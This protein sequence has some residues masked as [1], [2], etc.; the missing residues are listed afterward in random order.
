[1]KKVLFIHACV[2][3]FLL[4]TPIH[5][6]QA[7]QTITRWIGD[8]SATTRTVSNGSPN[9]TITYNITESTPGLI[10]YALTQSGTYSNSLTLTIALN[11]SGN[12]SGSYYSKAVQAG[13]TT[14]TVCSPQLG[15]AS[16]SPTNYTVFTPAS[17]V[18]QI[19]YLK[20]GAFVNVPSPLLNVLKG[21]TVTFKAIPSP[22]GSL[23]FY[24]SDGPHDPTW[25]GVS[26]ATGVGETTAVTFN[27]LSKNTKDY[28]TVIATVQNGGGSKTANVIVADGVKSISFEPID[29][30]S[31][32]DD[33]P[34]A[35][36]GKRVFPD[37]NSPS[38]NTV[39]RRKVRV[40]ALTTFGV[41]QTIYFKSFDL[42]DPSTDAAPVDSN[43]SVV[44]DNRG[45]IG[46]SQQYGIL[47]SVGGNGTTN[48]VSAI[49]DANG[50]ASVDLTVT[51][52][53]G[54]NFMVAASHDS[55]Y[56]NGLSG[57]GI[58]LKDSGGNTVGAATVKAKSS[59]MLTVWRRMHV[60][61]DSMGNV[62]GNN[63]TGVIQD[64]VV[65]PTTNT[66]DLLVNQTLEESRFENG[67]IIAAGVR[68]AVVS[69]TVDIV[70]I[71]GTSAPPTG[72]SFTLVD[73]DDFNSDDGAA[74][75]GDDNE[76]VVAL[77]QTFSR[78]QNSDNPTDNV[79]APAYIRPVYDGGGNAAND[80]GNVGFILNNVDNGPATLS[81]I[82][83]GRNSGSIESDNFW[84]VYVQIAYQ[85]DPTED[86]DPGTESAAGG[87]TP[88]YTNGTTDEVTSSASVTRGADGSLLFIETV[89]DRIRYPPLSIM[90]TIAAPHEVGHQFGLKGDAAG[91]G[92]MFNSSEAPVFVDKHLNVLRWR[93]KSPGQP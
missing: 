48:S 31:V 6:A 18:A 29:A 26:G 2:A 35:G 69:N 10:I 70:T 4:F 13:Q 25:S 66:T 46:T 63:V 83:S 93:V 89:R 52:Q 51:M 82:N 57:N 80:S 78:M 30:A 53:P 7:Q 88:S 28:K 32:I 21:E 37:K 77:A 71:A 65:D 45:G 68:Y 61:V 75:D 14:E 8:V 27:T 84:V 60:E 5:K 17:G 79:Y 23:F 42:D 54:D 40:K 38:D 12:G 19:Q 56:L 67:S 73:D 15:C 47:S 76:D 92:I 11:A 59:P 39:N 55:S 44:N 72:A 22:V 36:G 43:G 33:N 20:D 58:T 86:S 3:F 91:F 1:M 85:P 34:N 16:D 24:A 62:A 64:V 74:L 49:T 9:G 41:G 90:D 87:Y 81:Q 50:I